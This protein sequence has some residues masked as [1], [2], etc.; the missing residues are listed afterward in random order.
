M[1]SEHS[2]DVVCRLDKQEIVNAILQTEKEVAQ[3]FDFKGAQVKIDFDQTKM[4]LTLSAENDFRLKSLAD[5]LDTRMAKR[6]L[7]LAAITRNPIETG[8]SGHARQVY[9]LQA[10]IPVEKAKEIVKLVKNLKFK[11]QASIQSDQVRV[12]GKV[13]DELQSV[14]KEIRNAGLK[15][16]VEFV[17]YR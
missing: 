12:S 7:P 2:F 9:Q 4:T 16:H 11:V 14:Q 1:S 15:I 5:I 8:T 6:G 13:L 10:G 17:N 3:R